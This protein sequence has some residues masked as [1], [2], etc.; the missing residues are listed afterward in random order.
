MDNRER[1]VACLNH[2]QPDKV[3]YSVNF[4]K[5]A[6]AAMVEYYGD[7][8]FAQHLGNAL[9][10]APTTAP[11]AWREAVP[12]IWEDEFGV[13]WDQSVPSFSTASSLIRCWR[14]RS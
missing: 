5:P 10:E 7:R 2:Q 3:P 12:D 13:Q 1:V 14:R 11:G 8:S 6:W 9:T 4:T